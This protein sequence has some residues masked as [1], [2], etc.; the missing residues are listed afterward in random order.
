MERAAS[1]LSAGQ[2][3]PALPITGRNSHRRQQKGSQGGSKAQQALHPHQPETAG[4]GCP[5][6]VSTGCLLHTLPLLPNPAPRPAQSSHQQLNELT[7]PAQGL[8]AGRERF[9]CSQC[10]HSAQLWE[11]S[12]NQITPTC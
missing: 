9:C 8:G 11:D 4:G 6:P 10:V 5:S 12:S 7:W 2:A 3:L 1:T